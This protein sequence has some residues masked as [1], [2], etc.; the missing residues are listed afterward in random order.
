[1]AFSQ[2][3]SSPSSRDSHS[4]ANFFAHKLRRHV[5]PT[6]TGA[7]IAAVLGATTS[8]AAMVTLHEAG[9]DDIYS[10]AS[11]GT[12]PVDIRY[13]PTISHVD[14]S[15]LNIDTQAKLTGASGLF[16]L[17]NSNTIHYAYFVD[18]ISWCG[19]SNANIIGCGFEPGTDF[20]VESNVAAGSNGAE[21]IG[22][23]LGHNLNLSHDTLPAS[24]LMDPSLN[25]STTLTTTQVATILSRPSIQ[26]D[27]SGFFIE[28]QPVLILAAATVPEP[29]TMLLAVA[30]LLGT[31]ACNARRRV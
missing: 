19:T 27:S 4:N 29:S 2:F 20:V 10:Q 3:E 14:A 22:H 31:V 30:S 17:F 15:L 5:L 24:N 9:V 25:G 11:F 8:W 21:L 28:I 18:T 1:M 6:V 12:T 23:E 7:L 13:L 16:N 26:S